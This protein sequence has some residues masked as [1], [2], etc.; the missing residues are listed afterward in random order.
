MLEPWKEHAGLLK[1]NHLLKSLWHSSGSGSAM[2]LPDNYH[3]QLGVTIDQGL[4]LLGSLDDVTLVGGE[5][6]Q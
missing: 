2:T 3:A 4:V 1:H 5:R 6:V